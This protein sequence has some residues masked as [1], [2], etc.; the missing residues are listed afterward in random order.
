MGRYIAE[1]ISA[2]PHLSPEDVAVVVGQAQED[3]MLVTYLTHMLKAQ[4]SL[5]EKLGT[6][7]LPLM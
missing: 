2:V 1:T 6:L 3:V 7:Q 5:A 4:L